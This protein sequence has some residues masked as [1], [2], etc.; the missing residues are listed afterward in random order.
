[1]IKNKFLKNRKNLLL[2]SA[3]ILFNILSILPVSLFQ[4]YQRYID[5]NN[6]IVNGV[7]LAVMNGV[8]LSDLRGSLRDIADSYLEGGVM[9]SSLLLT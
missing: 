8:L 5:L 7:N 2:I 3:F 4:I 1:M 9:T 6:S